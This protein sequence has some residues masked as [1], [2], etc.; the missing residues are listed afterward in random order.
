MALTIGNGISIDGGITIHPIIGLITNGLIL[1]YD[2]STY[3]GTGDW[4]DGI[5][6]VPAVPTN[7]P[8]W[9]SDNGGAFTLSSPSTQ[10]FT[11]PWPT[12]QPTYTID[13]WFNFTA[14][15]VGESPCLISDDFSGAINF[16]INAAGNYILTGWNPDNWPGQYATTNTPVEF[17]HNGTTWYN[18]TM[19]VGA[20]QYK[21]YID[22]QVSYA[23]G[24]FG[25]GGT[26]PSGSGSAQQF[27][28]GKR[29]D[30]TDT[31][32]AKI[33]V[34]NIYDRALTDAEVEQNFNYYQSRFFV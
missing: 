19:S 29:W 15:Q 7:T 14:S 22:G 33:A 11:V 18:I 4:I 32:N 23:P 13:I 8:T 26:A 30:L 10:Y 2:A 17:T 16:T 25:P 34:V 5:S 28:I 6:G 24:N 27:Y 9:S 3:S 1:N 12:F 20:T 21:D 31:V